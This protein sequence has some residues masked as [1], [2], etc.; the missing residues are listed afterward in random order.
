[1]SSLDNRKN[2]TLILKAIH[3]F[4]R[5][6]GYKKQ[7]NTFNRWTQDGLC[8]VVNLQMSRWESGQFTVNL[9]IF[10][11]EI[12]AVV[13]ENAPPKVI[14]EYEC[15]LRTRLGI[16]TKGKD[17]WWDSGIPE[18]TAYENVRLLDSH[19]LTFLERFATRQEIITNLIEYNR[20]P[21]IDWRGKLDIAIILEH[22]GQH[23]LANG[24]F[25]QY[26][27]Q[28]YTRGDNPYHLKFLEKLAQRF[29]W[30]IG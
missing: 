27:S 23:E 16:L 17:L 7:A 6:Q 12:Y 30:K 21:K 11:P 8:Q 15:A 19:G 9:G 14:K 22:Q 4:L 18:K 5:P 13:D 3:S 25:N 24:A 20:D 1:M 26:Y 2:I 10:I 29:S 28:E